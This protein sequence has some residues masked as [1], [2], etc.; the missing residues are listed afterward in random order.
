M[1]QRKKTVGKADHNK[2]TG[3]NVRDIGQAG[4]GVG[5]KIP[6]S[7]TEL[8]QSIN[9]LSESLKQIA[10]SREQPSEMLKNSER[11]DLIRN[12]ISP[13]DLDMLKTLFHALQSDGA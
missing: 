10:A 3:Q 8:A 11:L 4:V 2:S 9:H 6:T 7:E 1:V 13:E 5:G 12:S